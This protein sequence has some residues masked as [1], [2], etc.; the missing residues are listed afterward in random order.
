[1]CIVKLNSPFLKLRRYK[2]QKGAEYSLSS[3][4]GHRLSGER[5]MRGEERMSKEAHY[6]KSWPALVVLA[7][8]VDSCFPFPEYKITFA[9]YSH[10]KRCRPREDVIHENL[11]CLC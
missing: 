2:R 4:T 9:A 1:M 10:V 7:F 11:H 8:G 3:F 5:E 6:L